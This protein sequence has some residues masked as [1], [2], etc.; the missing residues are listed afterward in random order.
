MIDPHSATEGQP[1][2]HVDVHTSRSSIGDGSARALSSLD[3]CLEW[4]Y[5]CSSHR[6]IHP[7]SGV[8]ALCEVEW[9][10]PDRLAPVA[11]QGVRHACR[12]PHHYTCFAFHPFV[13]NS[14]SFYR[15]SLSISIMDQRASINTW[16]QLGQC[17]FY[18]TTH[19]RN[20]TEKETSHNANSGRELKYIPIHWKEFETLK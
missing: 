14:L 3:E 18:I 4:K 12:F 10:I 16:F 6:T 8:R 13:C 15:P 9:A 2:R 19:R 1:L 7:Q 5:F 17:V 20:Q 11:S